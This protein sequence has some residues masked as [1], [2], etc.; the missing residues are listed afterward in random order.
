MASLQDRLD[1]MTVEGTLY[2]VVDEADKKIRCYACGHRCLIK[3]GGRGICKVRYNEGGVLRVP[4]GYIGALQLDPIEKKPFNHVDPGALALSF[5][6]LGCDFH[7]S[8]CFTPDTAI[9]TDRGV[10]AI[11]DLFNPVEAV[12][13]PHHAEIAFP[14]DLRT[15][16]GSGRLRQVTKV[17]KHLY[18]GPLVVIKPY[19]LPEV[20]CTPD[21]R[22]YA[23]DDPTQPPQRIEAHHLTKKHFLAIPR[24]YEVAT[25][26]VVDVCAIL[27][28]YTPE[29]K[30]PHELPPEV[31][32]YIMTAS[33]T[34]VS[35][36]AL[37]QELG[38]D[39]SYIRHV[40]SKVQRGL[41]TDTKPARLT[42][43]DNRVR[44][45]KERRPGIAASIPV[46]ESFATLLGYYCAEGSI[47]ENKARPNS[48]T[49][50]FTFGPRETD[51]AEET[52]QLLNMIFGVSPQIIARETTL[53]V[54]VGKSSIGLLFKSLCGSGATTKRVPQVII[55]SP[56]S[57]IEAFLSAYLR[58]DGHRTMQG[59]ISAT[60]KSWALAYN[61]AWLGLKTGKLVS[62]YVNQVGSER[63]IQGRQVSQSPVQYSM[64]WY[65][66]PIERK[67]IVT[68]DF[69]LIPIRSLA[70]VEYDGAVYNLEVEEEHTYLAN[71][72][73]VSNC[74]NWEISQHG[75]DEDAGRDPTPITPAE[76]VA[77]GKARGAQSIASTYNEPLITSEWAVSV[78]KVAR[79]A[80]MRTLY[81]SNGN[82]TPEAVTYLRPWLD[83]Y[84]I[85]LKTMQDK[86]YRKLGGVLQNVLDSIKRVKESG[87]WTEVVTLVVP[88]FNDSNDELWDAARYI[89]SVSPDIPWHIT[90][91]HPDYRMTDPPATTV[92]TLI[93]AAEIG[94]E[95][96]LNFVYAGN[97]P[98]R[99]GEWEH[100]YCP[101]CHETVVRRFGFH[102]IENRLKATNGHCPKCNTLVPGVWA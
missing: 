62:L 51:L 56:P 24:Q 68:D 102:V 55:D 38:K 12:V 81:I 18:N 100:T 94:V 2:E 28:A 10:V 23:T 77:L 35:S 39:P 99:V 52:R 6:M 58:G 17:F 61:V 95:A 69:Y 92:D 98:G 44:F 72:L 45:A 4:H 34:G 30:V 9:V 49:L 80:G 57:V 91:F 42:I 63:L 60:T 7:C 19:Y 65:D 16:A 85:D 88:G 29:F 64:V 20:R 71:F 97:L 96:G 14:R 86:Q 26:Q 84:K 70:A 3:D 41:W 13:G 53:A 27:A 59:K 79:Q 87:L 46:D 82:T 90:A 89:A 54:A 47:N 8:Y 36:R 31:V 33:A 67:R 101:S 93:R 40:R 75:R 5:G 76:L 25:P 48:Y 15:I 43:E 74:Q 37:G 73:L 11:S 66:S 1:K 22:V 32:E 50:V 21:H 78:F 83:A